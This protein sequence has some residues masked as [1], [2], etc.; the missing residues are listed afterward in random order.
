M[1]QNTNREPVDLLSDLLFA[2]INK[3]EDV[4]YE[5]EVAVINETADYFKE[6]YSGTRYNEAFFELCQKIINSK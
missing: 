5:F 4:P 1:K 2:Y 6:Q 3:D